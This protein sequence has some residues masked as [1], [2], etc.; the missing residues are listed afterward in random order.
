MGVAV[1]VGG[2]GVNV[3]VGSGLGVNVA[4]TNVGVG[5]CC[6]DGEQAYN[7]ARSESSIV[8]HIIA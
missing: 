2:E 7:P 1:S 6:S 4:G 5:K 3:L 8:V